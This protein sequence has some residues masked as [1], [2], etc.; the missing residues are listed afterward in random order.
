VFLDL[1][2]SFAKVGLLAWGGGPAMVP[3]LRDEVLS[4]GWMSEAEFTDALATDPDRRE[5][6]AKVDVVADETFL[7][8]YPYQFPSRLTVETT[9]GHRLVEEVLTNRG[10]SHRPLSTE[11]LA[12]KFNDNVDGL[13]SPAAAD[14]LATS[15]ADLASADSVS[16]VLSPLHL[17]SALDQG[18]SA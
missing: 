13:L 14:Q 12:A 15:L 16:D 11:E 1:M 3:L 8:I 7:D 18:A 2:M 6:M 10:G 9:D 5:L 17:I 4:K